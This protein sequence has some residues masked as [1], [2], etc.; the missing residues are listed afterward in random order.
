MTK[1]QAVAA[2]VGIL[3][4]LLVAILKQTGFPKWANSIIAVLACAGAGVL[5]A[6]ATG[7]LKTGA[8]LVAIATIFTVAQV[9]YLA[10]FKGTGLDSLADF[11]SII[12]TPPAVVPI[13][14]VPATTTETPTV[15]F[16]ALPPTAAASAETPTPEVPVETPPEAP[17]T[18]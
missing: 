13:N 8:A 14:A 5:T 6:L 7:Q 11:T 3:M 16:N 1:T 10:F 18:P 2:I 12:K 15:I 4:P 17:P 9:E